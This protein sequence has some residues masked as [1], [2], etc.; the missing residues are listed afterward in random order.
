ML[1]RY[2]LHSD[3]NNFYASVECLY[4][5]TIKDKP[6]AVVGDAEKRHGIVLAKNYIAKSFGVKTGDTIYTAKTKCGD[7]LVC[8]TADFDKYIYM[9]K[10]V[11]DYY[12]SITPL[13]ES[14]GIDEAWLDITSKVH[15]W[16]EAYALADKLRQDVCA[17]FGITVSVGVSYNKVFAKLGSDLHKPNAVTLISDTNYKELL[18]KLPC[19]DLLY[20]GRATK[21]KLHKNNIFSIGDLAKADE[22]FLRLT[23]GKMGDSLHKFACG[24]D[25]SPVVPDGEG[26]KIKSVGN[27]TTCP[28][29]L[30]TDAEV[31]ALIYILAEHEAQRMRNKGMYAKGVSLGIRDDTLEWFEKQST[32]LSA[33]NVASDIASECFKLFRENYVW[34]HNVRAVGV[35]AIN[36]TEG[37]VQVN[38]FESAESQ[39][40]KLKL[41]QTV[42]KLRNRYG[43]DIIK[44][45]NIV[46]DSDFDEINPY[47]EKHTIH[48]VSYKK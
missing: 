42:E 7:G 38:I 5:P 43:Y 2:I 34:N 20:V 41:E 21:D 35:R 1:M 45:G 44:R 16:D 31:K 46:E 32:L 40:K 36:L 37:D 23:F 3:L 6:V 27:S 28:R 48:P 15:S 17:N 22:K 8:V 19:E 12:R 11:K 14:F 47:A 24:L 10:L 29:D 33:T 26:E 30:K 13:V 9:S 4:N 39:D 18:Y 25:D